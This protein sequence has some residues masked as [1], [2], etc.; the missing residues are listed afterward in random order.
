MSNPQLTIVI[1]IYNEEEVLPKVIPGII[2][3]ARKRNIHVIGVNDG[4]TDKSLEVLKRIKDDH[5]TFLNHKVNKG[6]GGALKTGIDASTTPYT[7]TIDGDGQH[8]LEDIDRLLA[9]ALE[10]DADMIVGSRKGLPSA[11]YTRAIGKWII[12]HI[13]K[14]LMPLHIQDINSGMKLY[15]TEL[16]QKY[17]YLCPNSMAFSDIITLIFINQRHKVI[18]EPI[19]IKERQGGKS[20]IGIQTAF[21][22]VM[23]ILN[24]IIMFNPMKI[25]LPISLFSFIIGGAWS[26]RFIL[27]GRGFPVAS[28]IILTS[29]VITF[30]LGLVAEQLSKIRINL[31]HKQ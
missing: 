12:F 18:E 22:T 24:I 23:E 26:I 15:N 25:F 19:L 31:Y 13:A 16:A 9:K 7:I 21:Q 6:Y 17:L 29:S 11:S 14:I 4:S 30:L 3:F 1:P 8:Y 28:S 10:T 5:F 2:S 27:M 20:T